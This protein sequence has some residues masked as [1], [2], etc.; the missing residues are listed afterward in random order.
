M[1]LKHTY[2]FLSD[3]LGN[4]QWSLSAAAEPQTGAENSS[5]SRA[6]WHMEASW[7]DV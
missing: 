1:Q 7:D 5:K 2:D 4:S 6:S 3:G